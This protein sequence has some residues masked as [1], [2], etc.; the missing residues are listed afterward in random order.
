MPNIPRVLRSGVRSADSGPGPSGP[1]VVLEP[2]GQHLARNAAQETPKLFAQV[3]LDVAQA[4]IR[5]AS[6]GVHHND[7]SAMNIVE[8][9]GRYVLSAG[10]GRG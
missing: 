1:Y 3:A 5:A 7:V 8:R 2:Y 4:I 10:K 6:E 9:G